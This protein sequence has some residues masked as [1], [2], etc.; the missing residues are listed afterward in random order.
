MRHGLDCGV[1]SGLLLLMVALLV[2]GCAPKVDPADM[3]LRNGK[4]V[5]VDE[6]RPEAQALAVRGDTIVAIGTDDEIRPYIGEKT[7]V[8]DLGGTL[9]I[10]GLIDSHVH[11]TGIGTNKLQL[12]LMR[13]KNWNEVIAM[14]ADAVKKAKPGQLISG[15]GWHQEKWDTV[16]Q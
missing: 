10:P 16:P 5:T 12:D 1:V 9:A 11:F 8:I 6:A 14:V 3:V 4:I 2:P 7:E 15:R 13:V